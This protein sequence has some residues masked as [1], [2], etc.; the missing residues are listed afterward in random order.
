M[1]ITLDDI[2]SIIGIPVTMRFVSYNE[3]MVYQEAQALLVDALGV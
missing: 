1:T 3:R 2:A